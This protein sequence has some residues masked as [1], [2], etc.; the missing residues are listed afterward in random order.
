M[1]TSQSSKDKF[2]N[3]V[4]KH[5]TSTVEHK[6]IR[7]EL[8]DHIEDSLGYES[9]E[10]TLLNL[11]DPEIIGNELNDLY[12]PWIGRLWRASIVII[13]V[14]TVILGS[15]LLLLIPEKNKSSITYMTSHIDKESREYNS[16]SVNNQGR[17]VYLRTITKS[18]REVRLQFLSYGDTYSALLSVNDFSD[19][20]INGEAVGFRAAVDPLRSVVTIILV[21]DIYIEDIETLSIKVN[22]ELIQITQ[23]DE[24]EL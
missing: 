20:V 21:P 10:D 5:V 2:L 24:E 11:G 19:L 3:E 9:L 7:K 12:K 22:G 17:E 1:G 4:C 16:N 23:S 18:T 13:V 6:Q 15:S 14:L 8:S